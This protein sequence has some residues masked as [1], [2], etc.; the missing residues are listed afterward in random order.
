MIAAIKPFLVPAAGGFVLMACLTAG[1][2][3]DWKAE[4]AR[5][6][7]KVRMGD[8]TVQVV[9]PGG[10]PVPGAKVEATL[11]DHAFWFG[12]ALS[13]SM[14]RPN[15]DPEDA[16]RYKE[17]ARELFN[18]AVHENAAKWY[19][20]QRGG[21]EPDFADADRVL[22]WCEENGLRM[23]GH[24]I[25]WG[26]YKYVP[27]WQKPLSDE[28]LRRAVFA[29]AERVT[30]HFRT[31]IDEWDLNNEMCDPNF[32]A[33]RLGPE[34]ILDMARQ[35]RKGNPDVVLY[36]ND[37][38]ML[39]GSR[40]P[41]YLKQVRDLLERGVPI[42]GIGV[43]G[44]FG[45]DLPKPEVVRKSLDELAEFGLPIRITEY[46]CWGGANHEE[47]AD[48]LEV[49]YR[50]AFAHPAVTGIL[51]WGFWEGRHWQPPAALYSRNW[52]IRPQGRRY[53]QLV[54]KKW[55]TRERGETGA[56]G[57]WTFRGFYGTYRLTVRPPGKA[58]VEAAAVLERGKPNRIRI[59]VAE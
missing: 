30:R 12:T 17:V 15:A 36:V 11:R 22:E 40:L 43:Q 34:I 19:H 26:K 5:A 9:G 7:A 14:F 21:G 1:A 59:Q 33:D 48:A 32:Y 31:R 23:R 6:I 4:T 54:L 18:S 44:H 50:V 39:N 51:G 20:T 45:G 29:R 28:A 16:A 35:A 3:A 27:E 57:Q 25:F 8:A 52:S 46:D 38:G 2:A 55:Q 53:R 49:V 41:P 13:H 24:C 37:Y 58:A 47:R 56:D 42:G 10:E